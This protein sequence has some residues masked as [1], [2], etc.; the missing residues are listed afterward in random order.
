M[1]QHVLALTL[2]AGAALADERPTSPLSVSL[3]TLGSVSLTAGR[4]QG[5]VGGGV[6]VAFAVSPSWQAQARVAWLWGLGSHTLLRVGGGW[7]R[8]GG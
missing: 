3:E 6:G 4:T 2:L 1:K 8:P 7:Q 5:G